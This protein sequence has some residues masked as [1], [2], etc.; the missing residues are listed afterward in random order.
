MY[1]LSFYGLFWPAGGGQ[2]VV[3]VYP[4]SGWRADVDVGAD[5]MV[6]APFGRYGPKTT[7]NWIIR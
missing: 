2:M 5:D 7:L 1:Y 4:R 6:P 3:A